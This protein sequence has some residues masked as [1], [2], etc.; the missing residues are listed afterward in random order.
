[1]DSLSRGTLL[2]CGEHWIAYLQRPGDLHDTGLVS[3]YHGYTSPVGTGTAAFVH[4]KGK[5]GLTALYTDN[6]P[7]AEFVK[8]TQLPPAFPFDEDMPLID[9][10]FRRSENPLV[11]PTWK[12]SAGG[13]VVD[14]S[15]E[16]L[17]PPLVGPPTVNPNIVFTVL[18]FADQGHIEVNGIRV[19][20]T[21]YLRS[22]WTKSLGRPMSS[23][24]FAMAETMISD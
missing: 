22:A 17:Q 21:P 8:K 23:F 11:N 3:L 13:Y 9:A 7:F 24:C 19:S 16:S 15:W 18:V 12:I 1:M 6:R 5:G 20:G 14:I 4:I 10:E 2:W